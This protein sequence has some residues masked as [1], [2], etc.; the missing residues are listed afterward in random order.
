MKESQLGLLALSK[1]ISER[2]RQYLHTTFYFRDRALRDSFARALESEELVKG[3]FLEASPAFVRGSTP[4]QL[5]AELGLSPDQGF[6]AAIEGDRPLY[7]HQEDAIRKSAM[8]RNVVV[9]T[10]TGSGKT[11]SF[12]LP[13]LFHLYSQFRASKLG[14]GVRALI[15]YP[16]NALTND[17]RDRLG[18]ISRR[19]EENGSDFRFTF[20]QYIGETPEDEM[21]ERRHAEE[22]LQDRLPGE[23]VYRSEMRASPPHILLTNYSMLEYLLIRPDDSPLFDEGNSRWWNFLILDEAHQYRGTRGIEMAMLL[24]R[25]QQRLREGGRQARLQCIATSATLLG[26]EKDRSAVC[27]FASALFGGEPFE[28]DDVVLGERESLPEVGRYRLTDTDYELIA[29]A[30]QSPRSSRGSRSDALVALANRLGGSI[31]SGEDTAEIMAGAILCEDRRATLLRRLILD[32]PCQARDLAD[33][34]FP[35]IAEGRRL[36]ALETLILALSLARDPHARVTDPKLRPPLLSSRYHLFLRSLEG[37]FVSYLPGPSVSLSRR[38]AADAASFEIALCRECGQHYLVGRIEGGSRSGHLKEAVRDLGSQDFGVTFFKPLDGE[39]LDESEDDDETKAGHDAGTGQVFHL[40]IRCGAIWMD[41]LPPVCKHGTTLELIRQR[42]SETN[43]DQLSRCS[44]CGYQGADPVKEVVHGADGPNAVIATML[45]SRLPKNRRKI[46]AFAD[47]RQDAAFFA[48]YLDRTYQDVLYR[49]LILT[50]A[51]KLSQVSPEGVSLHD[52]ASEL[53]SAVRE[54]DLVP[55]EASQLDLTREAWNAIY[56]EFM[57]DQRRISLEGLGLGFWT[58]QWPNWIKVPDILLQD[59]WRLNESEARYLMLALLNSMRKGRAV[60]L[61]TGDPITLSWD[62]LDLSPQIAFRTGPS[63][64]QAGI[65]AWDGPNSS[66]ARLLAK[67]LA[68]RGMGEEDAQKYAVL[69]LQE[70]WQAIRSAPSNIRAQNRLLLFSND[71]ARLNPGWWRFVAVTNDEELLQCDT[72]GLLQQTS[73]FGLCCRPA[74]PGHLATARKGDLDS[75]HYRILY[76]D[77]LPGRLRVEEHTAQLTH[78]RA[79]EFQQDFKE[80]RIHVLSCSTTFELGVDLGNLDTVFLR[81]VPP[82]AFNYAQRIGR[83]GRRPGHPGFAVTYCRRSP[84]DLYHFAEPERMLCGTTKPFAIKLVNPKILARHMTAVALSYF[85]RSNKDRFGFVRSF[86]QDLAQPRI[87]ADLKTFL[88]SRREEVEAALRAGIPPEAHEIMGLSD[89]RW[90]EY[91]AGQ[92]GDQPGMEQGSRLAQAELELA[93]DYR[94]VR[95]AEEEF[96]RRKRYLDAKWAKDRALTLENEDVLSFLSRK[97]VIPKYGFPVDVVSLDTQTMTFNVQGVQLQRDL[98]LAIAEFAPSSKVVADKKLWVSYGLKKVTERSWDI[99]YYGKCTKHNR[100]DIWHPGEVP[101]MERCCDHMT[102]GRKYIIPQ[103][104]FIT[105]REGPQ[106]PKRRPE[107][108]FSTRPFFIQLLDSHQETIGMPDQAPVIQVTRTSPGQMG[109]ICEGKRGNGFYICPQCGAG[110]QTRPSEHKTPLGR[111]CAG[112]LELYML[113]HEFTTDVLLMR[114]LSRPP[115]QEVQEEEMLWFGYSLAYALVGGVSEVL[116]VPSTDISTTV[117]Y[118]EGTDIP[119]IV[120][121]DNVPGGAGLVARLE[122]E[123]AMRSAVEAALQRVSGRC[124]CG[125]NDS[126]YGCLRSYSNQFAH[127]RLRRGPVMTYLDGLLRL[128]RSKS[129][130]EVAAA[131][132]EL[133]LRIVSLPEP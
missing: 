61:T 50:T 90:I 13:I 37:A 54:L 107:R 2:Y 5:C 78:Q 106:E 89:G 99:H 59:P 122:D 47:G 39:D 110:F 22:H 66:R 69:T 57:T 31:P 17:Q 97:A 4:R 76:L 64:G 55:P 119:P 74:C 40:C 33:H 7:K 104:G 28:P 103:F 71:A 100:F 85:F 118:A 101:P 16:M 46:L 91:V 88:Y 21:D 132:E 83:A 9:A 42:P 15:L 35:D 34:V 14:P 80:G 109:I 48:W 133:V 52:L 68:F 77:T 82:E 63:R 113:G 123:E 94:R 49:R 24:R 56:R 41:G 23:L 70:I 86:L 79:R 129:R 75:N 10:G 43:E 19:L 3:P 11:E 105:S 60:E 6:L 93:D 67:L 120:L 92:A 112:K 117:G 18:E 81:N 27:N 25:L 98:G 44:T 36:E 58:V 126:C 125:Y 131:V 87:T 84:H 95:E 116:E 30:L 26:G 29:Q 114:F 96:T 20:G 51:R 62:D 53:R 12:L 32:R 1:Y 108:V 128:W 127:T 130:A 8:G 102:S 38:D 65:K 124:G 73:V 115:L 72:C 45:Y 111:P 121:Y